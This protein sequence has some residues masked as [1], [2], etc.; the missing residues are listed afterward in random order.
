MAP[1]LQ[2]VFSFLFDRH[3]CNFDY[4]SVELDNKS[5]LVKIIAWC[6]IGDKPLYE[7]M[8]L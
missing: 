8:I 6:R 3:S 5:A 7:A 4:N 1:I 2:T